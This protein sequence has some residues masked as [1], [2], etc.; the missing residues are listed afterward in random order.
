M[1]YRRDSVFNVRPPVSDILG[2]CAINLRIHDFTTSFTCY[3]PC[4]PS[5]DLTVLPHSIFVYLDDISWALVP[6][7][8]PFLPVITSDTQSTLLLPGGR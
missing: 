8:L 5:L 3:F 4:F 6:S 2:A 7:S 1:V